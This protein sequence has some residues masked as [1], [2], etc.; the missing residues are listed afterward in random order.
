MS[1]ENK[2]EIS[3]NF[4]LDIEATIEDLLNPEKE[5]EIDPLTNEVK[6]KADPVPPQKTDETEKP[7]KKQEPDDTIKVKP[8][9]ISGTQ[10]EPDED[11]AEENGKVSVHVSTDEDDLIGIKS[12]E[13][14]EETPAA[15]KDESAEAPQSPWEENAGEIVNKLLTSMMSLEWE[16][17]DQTLHAAISRAEALK[18]DSS[19]HEIPGAERLVSLVAEMLAI[20]RH[21]PDL[22][23]EAPSAVKRAV[24][25]IKEAYADSG[26]TDSIS[27]SA[28]ELRNLLEREGEDSHDTAEANLHEV[29]AETEEPEFQLSDMD[30]ADH[31]GSDAGADSSPAQPAGGE[32]ETVKKA[33]D[34]IFELEM[35][36]QE[37]KTEEE[38]PAEP[39]GEI[40]EESGTAKPEPAEAAPFVPVAPRDA[41]AAHEDME[42]AETDRGQL[43]TPAVEEV[44]RAH[45]AELHKL[46]N[47]IKPVEQLLSRTSGMEK[48]YVFQRGI[49]QKLE[50]QKAILE[51]ILAG[52]I[53][54]QEDFDGSAP[55]QQPGKPH[56]PPKQKPEPCPWADLKA[57]KVGQEKIALPADEIAY[58]G[59]IAG[60]FSKKLKTSNKFALSWLKSWPWS[61][62]KSSLSGPL[63]E[64]DE[65]DLKAME[66]PI[67]NS[68]IEGET[69]GTYPFR[70]I[71]K[72]V[73]VIINGKNDA[74][75]VLVAESMPQDLDV[76]G[77]NQWISSKAN[78]AFEAGKVVINGEKI[79]VVTLSGAA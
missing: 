33:E 26:N 54:A 60:R 11:T 15:S 32:A 16:I 14:A 45:I 1:D 19:I 67:I 56:S 49:R 7:E 34:Q 22:I 75:A 77:E 2:P 30:A 65:K 24:Y 63:A 76:T 41:A 39:A 27:Q 25:A 68:K 42:A 53:P 48:L 73:I 52:K 38:Q 20:M 17:D 74:K 69:G 51:N 66:L 58:A 6:A 47:K 64:L 70:E 79:R 78:A 28:K 40:A 55:L 9:S 44:L 59:T 5:I 36:P 3:E 18:H 21:T 4:T 50:K 72:P 35:E 43:H 23:P 8:G 62:I 37:E 13:K 57:V 29:K 71:R 46:T 31:G 61:K 10:S 12:A